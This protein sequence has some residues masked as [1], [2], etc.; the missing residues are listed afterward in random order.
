MMLRRLPQQGLTLVEAV[1]AIGLYTI[2]S[3]VLFD[4][5]QDLY[6]N[7]AYNFAQAD[8]VNNARRGL[9]AMTQDIREMTFSEDGTFPVVEIE[10]HRFGFYSDT[11]QDDSVEYIEFVLASTTLFKYTYNATGSP[12][13]YNLTTPDETEILSEYV[14]NIINGTST[15]LYYDTNNLALST[16]SLLTDV[17]YIKTQLIVNIDPFRAPGEFMLQSGIAPRNL[18]DNL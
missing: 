4:T 14:Q 16:S 1:I 18:K 9:Y 8:E 7:N 2:L 17:R 15:F 11:D 5:I 12:P 10:P 3:L 6:R 13:A